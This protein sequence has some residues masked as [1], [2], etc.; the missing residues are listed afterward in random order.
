MFLKDFDALDTI[1]IIH[2][3]SV[4]GITVFIPE[5]NTIDGWY[6]KEYLLKKI[7]V[8]LGGHAAEDVIYSNASNGA[9]ADF[10]FVTRIA[11]MMVTRYGLSSLG[12]VSI[13]NDAS[14]NTKM[15]V[16]EEVRSVIQTEYAYVVQILVK[17]RKK[18]DLIATKLIQQETIYGEEARRIMF[19]ENDIKNLIY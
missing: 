14:Q 3:G 13:P 10:E 5:E 9:V 2:R 18:M 15:L 16:D 17:H 4:G 11:T 7:R 8:G 6:T 12:K 1:S 19:E